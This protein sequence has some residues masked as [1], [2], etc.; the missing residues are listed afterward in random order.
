MRA[1]VF[2][3]GDE[4]EPLSGPVKVKQGCV[5]APVIFN[6]YVGTAPRLNRQKFSPEKGIGLT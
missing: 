4:T 6:L 3:G 5:M 2:V 1:S